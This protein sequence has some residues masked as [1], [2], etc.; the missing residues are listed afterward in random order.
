MFEREK[1]SRME[2]SRKIRDKEN[3]ANDFYS[4]EDV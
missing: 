3:T 2:Y 4:E 1:S